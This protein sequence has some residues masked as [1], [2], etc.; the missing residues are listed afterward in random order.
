MKRLICIDLDGTLLKWNK[1]IS[2]F[3]KKAIKNVLEKGNIVM[4]AT[5]RAFENCIKYADELEMNK[6]GGYIASYNGSLIYDCKRKKILKEYAIDFDIMSEIFS[7]LNKRNLEFTALHND[8][9]Y[10]SNKRRI[11]SD[12]YRKINKKEIRHFERYK[13]DKFPIQKI[14]VNDRKSKLE[15][16]KQSIDKK[17]GEKVSTSISSIVSVEITP[18]LATKGNAMEYIADIENINLKDTIAIGNQGNDE[19]MLGIA[20]T[21]VAVKNS[22]SKIKSLAKYIVDSNNDD[23][24]GKFLDKYIRE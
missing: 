9:Q 4:L 8:V 2:K 13:D 24:V 12:I 5:G 15:N 14:L 1:K 20:G 18:K 17:F 23:G 3:N 11:A 19:T 7:F 10:V 22:T 21:P 16:I 6:Y